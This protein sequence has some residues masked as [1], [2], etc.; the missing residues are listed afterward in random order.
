VFTHQDWY[1]GLCYHIV[2][3]AAW[4]CSQFPQYSDWEFNLLVASWSNVCYP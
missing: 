3:S 4:C 1:M 2:V